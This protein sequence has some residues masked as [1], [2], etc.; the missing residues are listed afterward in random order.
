M[1]FMFFYFKSV[2]KFIVFPLEVN[3]FGMKLHL[4]I[5][6]MFVFGG[7]FDFCMCL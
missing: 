5:L 7:Y 1:S 6:V 3:I 2:V 4:C